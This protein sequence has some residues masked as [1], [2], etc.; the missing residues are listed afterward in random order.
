MK[1]M[2]NARSVCITTRLTFSNLN[3]NLYLVQCEAH[4]CV[5]FCSVN[6]GRGVAAGHVQQPSPPNVVR[7]YVCE[8]LLDL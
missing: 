3:R 5:Q 2:K 4:S 7:R 1:H 8:K 6:F